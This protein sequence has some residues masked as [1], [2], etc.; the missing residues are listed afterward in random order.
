MTFT[1]PLSFSEQRNLTKEEAEAYCDF[2]LSRPLK[3]KVGLTDDQKLDRD[4]DRV[5][6]GMIR[7]EI[8]D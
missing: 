5:E 1:H 8:G 2:I 4:Y 3:T 7:A 6:G